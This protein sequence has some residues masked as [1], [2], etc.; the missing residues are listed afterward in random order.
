MKPVTRP[1]DRKAR[2]DPAELDIQE[3]L[4]A[5]NRVIKVVKGGRRLR[6]R[7]LVVVGDGKGH[8][9]V[10][11][12]KAAGV[13]EAIRKAAAV[14]RKELIEVPIARTTIPHEIFAKFESSKVLLKPARQG[15]GMI[16]SN[17]V[18]AVLELAGIT[19]IVAKS[20]G[21]ANRANVAKATILALANLKW[22]EQSAAEP[23][24]AEELTPE[25]EEQEL[26]AE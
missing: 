10:G 18:R 11:L 17:T 23:E 14:G 6:F 25:K 3:R 12:A 1:L 21:S 4:L 2:I 15:R 13:P 7:A 16:A 19:D 22:P 24:L 26:E 8:V 5:I 20:L 9:A